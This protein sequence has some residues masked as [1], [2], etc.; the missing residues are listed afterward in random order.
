[1]ESRIHPATPRK[2]QQARARGHVAKSSDLTGAV[3]LVGMMLAFVTVGRSFADYLA[4]ITRQQLS[5]AVV[6][7]LGSTGW[8]EMWRDNVAPLTTL[9]LPGLMLLLVLPL[10]THFVQT[11]FHLNPART[12][13]DWSRLHPWQGLLRIFSAENTIRTGFGLAKFLA[14]GTVVIWSLY[15]RRTDIVALSTMPVGEMTSALF[16]LLFGILL[17]ITAVLLVL[18]IVDFFYQ[19]R[20]YERQ[21]MMTTEELHQELREQQPHA[22]AGRWSRAGKIASLSERPIR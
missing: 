12:A 4:A 7:D 15:A 9:L 13:P 21:L 16:D 22:Q 1:M 6:T 17:E 3:L 18:A 20:K 11:R 8:L 2:R 19:R 14:I 5:T 10:G